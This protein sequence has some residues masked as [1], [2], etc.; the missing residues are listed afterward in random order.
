MLQSMGL[1]RIANNSAVT[2]V[3]NL[4]REIVVVTG[5]ITRVLED[6]EAGLAA[7]DPRILRSYL[8]QLKAI[9]SQMEELLARKLCIMDHVPASASWSPPPTRGDLYMLIH[10]T[11]GRHYQPV[12]V[13]SMAGAQ[14]VATSG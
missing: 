9:N 7:S 14:R 4:A 10:V 8:K 3:D 11:T 2:S 13:A 1:M 5:G 12:D 6:V